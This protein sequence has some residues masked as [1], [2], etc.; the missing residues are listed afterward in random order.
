MLLRLYVDRHRRLGT[1][2]VGLCS[3]FLADHDLVTGLFA[4]AGG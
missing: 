1:T 4:G 2:K 3:T